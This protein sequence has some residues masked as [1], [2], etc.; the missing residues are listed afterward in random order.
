M[1]FRPALCAG[2]IGLLPSVAMSHE[3]WISPEAYVIENTEK[4]QAQLRVGEEFQGSGYS[5]NP[6]RFERFEVLLDN[7]TLPVDGRLGD[8]PALN[9][10]VSND[11]LAIIVHETTD[12][13]LTY[14]KWEKFV[15]FTTHK[16]FTEVLNEHTERGLPQDRFK[17]RYRRFGKSLV[18]VGSG[19]GD[20]QAVGL[21]T[22]IVA[23]ANP[24]TKSGDTLPVR[25]LFEGAPR[26]D[27]QVELFE[28]AP[29]DTVNVTLHR[30]DATG[31]VD[32]P[33]KPGHAYLVD[34]VAM[35]PL[36]AQKPKDDPVWY[37]LWASLTF[38]VPDDPLK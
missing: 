16:D 11:G 20:D 9:M 27:V 23:L 6:R 25:V 37:S 30:T 26:A 4:L 34:A 29:D 28:R 24:Y 1:N 3:F 32:L 14:T 38:A 7:D 33:I 18:A 31:E 35:V 22:E 36:E 21:R 8:T 10:D 19:A 2:L 15:K 17:E 13:V 5:F 12:S